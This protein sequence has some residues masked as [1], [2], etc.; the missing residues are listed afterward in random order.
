MKKII[1]LIL[2]ATIVG[3]MLGL[4]LAKDKSSPAVIKSSNVE[5]KTYAKTNMDSWC[6]VAGDGRTASNEYHIVRDENGVEIYQHCQKCLTGVIT[7]HEDGDARC[8]FCG[9]K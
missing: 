7:G 2:M 5:E 1:A 9:S 8:T 3:G 6:P 4:S